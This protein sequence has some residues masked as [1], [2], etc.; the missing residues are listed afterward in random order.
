MDRRT[1]PVGRTN[2]DTTQ[3]VPAELRAAQ[4]QAPHFPQQL[5]KQESRRGER[6]P[7]SKPFFCRLTKGLVSPQTALLF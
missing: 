7:E 5:R 3:T 1:A 2:A 4:G 6:L